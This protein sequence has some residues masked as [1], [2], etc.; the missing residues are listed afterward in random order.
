MIE[1]YKYMYNVYVILSLN[2]KRRQTKK[3]DSS[4]LN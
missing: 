3:N 2:H 1:Q 4:E